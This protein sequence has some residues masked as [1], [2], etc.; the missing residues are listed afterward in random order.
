[1]HKFW[2]KKQIIGGVIAAALVLFIVSR[3]LTPAALP[4]VM[5]RS[6]EKG[7]VKQTI[8]TS[9]TVKTEQQ[10][11]YFSPL[12]AKVEVCKVQE[13]DAVEAGQVLLTYDAQDLENRKKEAALQN[14]E[15]YYGYQNTMDKNSKDT[16]EYSRSS[17][18]VEILEQQ[19]E[20]AKAEVRALKQY[21]TD[22]GCFLRE[23]QNDNHKNLAEEYQA[24]IDQATNQL[25]VKEEELAEFQSDLSEQK[26]IKNSTES[27]MMT[28]D[29][30][31]QAEAAKELQALKSAEVTDAVAQVSDGI[32]ADF[33]GIV[34]GVKAVDGS[35]VENGGE[36]FTVSSIEKVCVDVSFS[37]SDLEKIEEGQKAVATIAGKQYEGTVTRISRAAAKNEKGAS[38]IQGE[39]H[40]DNPDTDL[41][42]GVDAR[43]MVEGNKAENV[44][45]IPVEAINIGKDGSFVYVVT[46]GMVQKR[47]VTAGI[48]SD[49]YT[50]IKKGLEVGEQVIISVD[51]GIE[52]GMAVNPV[53]G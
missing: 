50:E 42:L 47:M 32:K 10:K 19:V 39:I 28:A 2:K 7:T 46:D 36:L 48:S 15:A 9:G 31:K 26:G 5:V 44:V 16:S 40:I 22:M 1:M 33:A 14:D 27:T 38:I 29:A 25:A 30:K 3:V 34:T 41:Y 35:N 11:T 23:A 37:K 12:A 45:M 4:M 17:H 6:A 21:L 49:E 51:A 20:N 18:D 52:E 24:K 53:E 13:G 43:V 8:D